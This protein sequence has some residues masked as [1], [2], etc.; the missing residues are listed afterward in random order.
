MKSLQ[1]YT[2]VEE[3]QNMAHLCMS[4]SDG[5]T[6]YGLASA[7]VP[8]PVAGEDVIPNLSTPPF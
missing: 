3:K 2:K 7:A 1:S 4:V 5:V 6:E 8:R